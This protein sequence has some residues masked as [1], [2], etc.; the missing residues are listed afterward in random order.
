MAKAKVISN[1]PRKS[2]ISYL[3]RMHW[4]ISVRGSFGIIFRLSMQLMKRNIWND[5]N[6]INKIYFMNKCK[7]TENQIKFY[8]KKKRKYTHCLIKN[9]LFFLLNTLIKR[10]YRYKIHK[11]HKIC[12]N[13]Q[14]IIIMRIFLWLIVCINW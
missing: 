2:I 4:D 5:F 13:D 11:Y 9:V 12:F 3:N 7:R 10:K 8:N 14:N 1:I 6:K